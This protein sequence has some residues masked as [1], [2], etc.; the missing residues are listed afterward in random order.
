MKA[1]QTK[2]DFV[3]ALALGESTPD[4]RPASAC[5]LACCCCR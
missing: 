4:A 1:M 2:L 3:V 5:S